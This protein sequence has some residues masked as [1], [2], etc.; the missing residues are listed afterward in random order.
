MAPALPASIAAI[1]RSNTDGRRQGA[2]GVV[3]QHDLDITPQG[4]QTRSHRRLPRVT[5]RDDG[6][7]VAPV[8]GRGERVGQRVALAAR[9][10]DDH[11]LRVRCRRSTRGEGMPEHRVPVDA[12]ER[13]RDARGQTGS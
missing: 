5:A 12:D 9:G 8:T 11:D 10:R 6:H 13:F 2:G 7:Q 4:S 1:T 3:H